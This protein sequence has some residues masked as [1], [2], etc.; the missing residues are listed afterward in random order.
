MKNFKNDSLHFSAIFISTLY[1]TLN[2]EQPARYFLACE[3]SQI[4][5]LIHVNRWQMN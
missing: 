2:L 5:Y 3:I 4:V 1:Y